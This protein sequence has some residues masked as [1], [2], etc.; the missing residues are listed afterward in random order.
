M[1]CLDLH[2]SEGHRLHLRVNELK[3]QME[4]VTREHEPEQYGAHALHDQSDANDTR[5]VA[6]PGKAEGQTEVGQPPTPLGPP[7]APPGRTARRPPPPPARPTRRRRA[8]P[9]P[10]PRAAQRPRPDNNPWRDAPVKKGGLGRRR[11]A[12]PRRRE[13]GSHC[14]TPPPLSPHS[15]PPARGP[16][17]RRPSTP[18]KA[19]GTSLLPPELAAAPAGRTQLSPYT[20]RRHTPNRLFPR[21]P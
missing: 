4:K 13:V 11:Q 1:Q 7:A 2:W 14:A 9:R 5:F 12:T 3:D 6:C 16:R 10:A 19:E 21:G 20:T 15:P 18:P 17:G 8:R